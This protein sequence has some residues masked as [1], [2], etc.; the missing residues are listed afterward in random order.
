MPQFQTRSVWHYLKHILRIQ[1]LLPTSATTSWF[2]T[3]FTSSLNHFNG[4]L[5]LLS[6]WTFFLST[7]YSDPGWNVR[8]CL[9]HWLWTRQ[10]L[11]NA[12]RVKAKVL[13]MAD[14][15]LRIW[16]LFMALILSPSPYCLS[17]ATL[18][19]WLIPGHTSSVA[20]GLCIDCSLCLECS[21]PRELLTSLLH[22][23]QEHVN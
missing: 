21:L 22:F 13:T 3:K 12:F 17:L 10:W 8:A 20:Q 2:L 4:S 7:H 19:S 6:L 18:C 1:T 9:P 5:Y 16:L 15:V 23:Y 11:P 14:K